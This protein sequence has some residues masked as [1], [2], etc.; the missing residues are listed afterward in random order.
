LLRAER[1]PSPRARCR[2]CRTLIEKDGWRLSLGVFEEGR[3]EPIGFIHVACALTYFETEDVL[4][5]IQR[6]CPELS[7]V[8]LEE[9]AR[10]LREAPPAA[11]LA[12]AKPDAGPAAAEG[13]EHE[14][15]KR[16]SG[17]GS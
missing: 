14:P 15:S 9:I 3:M 5:R 6:L 17:G 1:S 11:E 2:S 13:R 7:A 4:P 16:R 8:E 12:L 10:G